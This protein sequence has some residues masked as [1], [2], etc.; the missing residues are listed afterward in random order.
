MIFGS[1]FIPTTMAKAETEDYVADNYTIEISNTESMLPVPNVPETW[2][3][4]VTLKSGETV[5]G[6]GVSKYA[7]TQT[8][9]YTLV[10]VIHKEGSLT[11]VITE[12]AALHVA[13]VKKPVITT[14]DGYEEE[15][16]VGDE[17]IIQ[18]ATVEDDVDENLTATAELYLG[19]KK[20]SVKGDKFVFKK[21]GEYKLVYKATD[22]YGNEGIL[23]Y[24]FTVSK[25]ANNGMN[26]WLI[27][28][29]SVAVVALG[30]VL[31]VICIKKNKN[32]NEEQ[33][34]ED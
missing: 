21:K 1:L 4:R 13:D 20:L 25:K 10:Y 12:T 14:P 27:V 6:E 2:T 34:N 18:T 19:E 17:L 7:F 28:G 5:I 8:G 31:C 23:T 16:F 3:Y 33:E 22:S 15:Y 30:T 11:D 24:E 9:D 29:C 26:I 32:K